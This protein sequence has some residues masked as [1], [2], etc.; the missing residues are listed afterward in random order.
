[1]PYYLE[2]LKALHKDGVASVSS[3]TIAAEL[4]FNEVQV[5]K[6]LASV[7]LVGGRPKTG[8][9]VP[10]L[11]QSIEAF[12]GCNNIDK[13]A[14]VGAGALGRALLSYTGFEKYGLEIAVAFDTDSAVIGSRVRGTSVLSAEKAASLCRRMGIKI[15]IICVPAT[16]AQQVCDALVEGGVAAVWNFAPITLSAPKDILLHNENMAASLAM[17]SRH[18]KEKQLINA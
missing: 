2:H 11:I 14:L 17:L 7:S 3:P 8:F 1:M 10:E 16:A 15:G 5:R 12:L 13:A 9:D 18:L 6:D 4:R